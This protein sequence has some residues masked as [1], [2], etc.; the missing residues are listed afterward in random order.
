MSDLPQDMA[1][2]MWHA[3]LAALLPERDELEPPLLLVAD[4]EPHILRSMSRLVRG[5]DV[6]LAT[7]NDGMEALE[8]LQ[9]ERVAVLIFD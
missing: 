8:V 2:S 7:A 1:T 9:R 5:L 6:R 3:Q 4:D